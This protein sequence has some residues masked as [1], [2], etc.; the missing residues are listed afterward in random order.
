MITREA[1]EDALMD[2]SDPYLSPAEAA[3]IA[4]V[5]SPTL[6]AWLRRGKIPA[7][8]TPR[9]RLVRRS[10]LERFLRGREGVER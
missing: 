10:D 3:T 2:P 5:H 6:A 9:G 8:R 1:L 7:L 4:G